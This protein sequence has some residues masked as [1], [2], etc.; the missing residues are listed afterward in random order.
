MRSIILKDADSG[1]NGAKPAATKSTFVKR[2]VWA[3]AGK[4]SRVNA[5]LPAPLGLEMMMIFFKLVLRDC[6]MVFVF[7]QRI[8]R[9]DCMTE[10]PS[11]PLIMRG[12]QRLN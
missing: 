4:K 6:Y 3:S 1:L 5:V 7:L 12:A 8:K 2:S 11:E 9:V 10:L